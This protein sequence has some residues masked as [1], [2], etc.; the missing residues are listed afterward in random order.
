MSDP[1]GASILWRRSKLTAG[2][3]PEFGRWEAEERGARHEA[4]RRGGRVSRDLERLQKPA[5]QIV[6]R[7]QEPL[8]PWGKPPG[9]RSVRDGQTLQLP[10]LGPKA[11]EQSSVAMPPPWIRKLSGIAGAMELAKIGSQSIASAESGAQ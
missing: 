7:T 9:S 2:N 5:P 1:P 6:P 10:S 8:H 3:I 4:G 11:S